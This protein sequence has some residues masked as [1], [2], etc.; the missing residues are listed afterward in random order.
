MHPKL[1]EIM[2]QM[3]VLVLHQ[4]HLPIS[5]HLVSLSNLNYLVYQDNEILILIVQYDYFQERMVY[6]DI[7]QLKYILRSIH[8]PAYRIVSDR[9]TSDHI[10]QNI[11]YRYTETQRQRQILS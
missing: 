5:L 9:I 10:T 6:V 8:Q 1:E 3:L 7:I 11:H 4:Y 2:I